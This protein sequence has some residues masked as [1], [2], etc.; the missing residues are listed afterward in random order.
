ME[1]KGDHSILYRPVMKGDQQNSCKTITEMHSSHASQ[2]LI[3]FCLVLFGLGRGG[4]LLVSHLTNGTASF[5][6]TVN[7]TCRTTGSNTLAWR[8]RE[9]IGQNGEQLSLSPLG[10][11]SSLNSYAVATVTNTYVENGQ[12]VLESNLTIIVQGNIPTASVTCVSLG[13]GESDMT[14]FNLTSKD[15]PVLLSLAL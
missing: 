1:D 15:M 5:G 12:R 9:Y 3:Y 11:T 6:D 2:L 10:T 14:S 7:F 8:S 4:V 13:T